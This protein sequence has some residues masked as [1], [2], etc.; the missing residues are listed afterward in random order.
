MAA[1]RVVIGHVL[2]EVR[3]HVEDTYGLALPIVESTPDTLHDVVQALVSNPEE[4]RALADA[5]PAFVERVHSGR[6]SA[7]VL[8]AHWIHPAS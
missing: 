7:D 8:L 3:R 4:A 1:G 6:A 5:G 2:P